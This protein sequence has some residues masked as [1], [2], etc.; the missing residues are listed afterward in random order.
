[1][2]NDASSGVETA[3]LRKVLPPEAVNSSTVNVGA[4]GVGRANSSPSTE[5]GVA[6]GGSYRET[7]TGVANSSDG[8]RESASSIGSA[9]VACSVVGALLTRM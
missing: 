3:T 9:I 1:M 5:G 4:A 8:D 6:D 7:R 2:V